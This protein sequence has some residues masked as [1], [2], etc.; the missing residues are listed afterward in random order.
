MELTDIGSVEQWSR[1][2]VELF[3][4]YAMNCTVYNTAGVGITGQPRWCNRLCPV[5]KGN[6]DALAAICAPG[7]QNFMARAR[8]T[9]SPVIGE[10]DAGLVKIAVPVFANGD[11]LGTAG[12]CGRLPEGGEVETFLIEKTTGLDEAAVRELCAGL[13]P[14]SAEES[15][16]MAEFIERRIEQ[17]TGALLK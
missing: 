4:R 1:F 6:P 15:R 5:I 16:A 8:Q 14:I 7:N 10:C 3:E 13:V 17:Y 12:G 11:F 2:E 9:H